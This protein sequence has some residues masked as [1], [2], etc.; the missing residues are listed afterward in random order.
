MTPLIWKVLYVVVCLYTV[1]LARKLKKAEAERDLHKQRL[2]GLWDSHLNTLPTIL[3][4]YEENLQGGVTAMRDK[5]MDTAMGRLDAANFSA[6]YL[7]SIVTGF[8]PVQSADMAHR[9]YRGVTQSDI[10]MYQANGDKLIAQAREQV[11]RGRKFYQA[12]RNLQP[13]QSFP[14]DAKL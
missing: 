4:E 11:K 2:F 8:R 12:A 7:M 10:A 9:F 13:G 1:Y 3:K 6:G 14:E 5:D